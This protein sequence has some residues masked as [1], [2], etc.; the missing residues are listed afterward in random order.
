[1][2]SQFQE[3]Y[4]KHD[5]KDLS[6]ALEYFS[7]FGNLAIEIDSSKTL[8]DAIKKHILD[9]YAFIHSNIIEKTQGESIYHSVL[10]GLA[11]GDSQA[12][13][14]FKRAKVSAEDGPKILEHLCDVGLLV[15]ES[16]REISS[17]WIDESTISA[18]YHFNSPFMRFW[19]AF[20][21][22]IFK[23]IQEGDYSEFEERFNN[24]KQ[25]FFTQM[26]VLL[27]QDLVKESFKDDPLTQ[28]GSY[29]DRDHTIDIYAKSTSGKTIL[30]S[31]KYTN[32]KVKKNELKSLNEKA[33][34]VKIDADIFVLVSKTGFSSEVKSLKSD[35]LKLFSL[36]NFKSKN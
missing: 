17:S 10:T 23:G 14:A 8:I 26:F 27:S 1:M 28:M 4:D 24:K 32:S 25:E 19:F 6:E 9:E 7:V 18:R 2:L 33:L 3:F 20:V 15:K 30:G 29:W 13:T 34:H 22:P 36:R 31:C 21:S 16:S 5:I 11:V 12:H 35:R